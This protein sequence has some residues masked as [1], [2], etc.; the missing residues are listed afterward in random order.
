MTCM[1]RLVF[2]VA[3]CRN[4]GWGH[5]RYH[6]GTIRRRAARLR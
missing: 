2:G 4:A 1:Q 6:R 3:A 5:S